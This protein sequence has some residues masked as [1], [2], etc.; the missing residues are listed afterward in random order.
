MMI[1][2]LARYVML[3][4]F[5]DVITHNLV[6]TFSYQ[7]VCCVNTPL[8]RSSPVPDSTLPF[9]GSACRESAVCMCIMLD[10]CLQSRDHEMIMLRL[11]GSLAQKAL[12]IMQKAR[13]S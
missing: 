11:R 6:C 1:R 8:E 12:N 9:C 4:S 3:V 2:G 5:H 10:G 13:S 7:K